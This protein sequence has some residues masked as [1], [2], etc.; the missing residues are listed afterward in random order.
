M[1]PRRGDY[2]NP[3]SPRGE[4][5]CELIEKTTEKDISIHTPREGS[6]INSFTPDCFS[7]SFQSTLPARGATVG[8][9]FAIPSKTISIHTPRE[10]SD[11]ADKSETCKNK[12]SIHTPREGSEAKVDMTMEHYLLKIDKMLKNIEL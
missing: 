2:F 11:K 9:A 8:I 1:K 10:G 3:H 12:I 5:P 6:D 4:R 7:V